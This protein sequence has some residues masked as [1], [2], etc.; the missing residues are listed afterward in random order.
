[1]NI[2]LRPV[3]LVLRAGPHLVLALLLALVVVR[4]LGDPGSG[5]VV[6]LAA[7]IGVVDLVGIVRGDLRLVPARA[8]GTAPDARP[9]GR[10]RSAVAWLAVLVALWIALLTVTPEAVWLA[11][12]LFF[13][14][15]QILPALAGAATLVV[16]VGASVAAYVL[17]TGKLDVGAVLGPV[18]GAAFAAAA[19]HGHAALARESER[20]RL[21]IAELQVAHADLAAASR[22]EGVLAE[23]ERL[24]R[25]IHDTLAQGL[26]SI[27][28]LLR[29][30]ERVLD[31]A[32]TQ[33]ADVDPRAVAELAT[34]ARHVTQARETA[35]ENLVEARRLVRAWT[36][37]ELDAGGLVTALERLAA[38][39]PGDRGRTFVHVSGTA[40]PLGADVDQALLRVA[41]SAVGNA[42]RHADATRIDVTLSFMDDE[43]ALDV[44]DDGRGFDADAVLARGAGADSGFG[45]PGMRARTRALG[46]TL[47]VES[48]VGAGAAISLRVPLGVDRVLDGVGVTEG[49]GPVRPDDSSADVVADVPAPDGGAA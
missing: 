15:L 36:S 12:P 42:V 39:R 34:A 32:A 10:S 29:A 5:T 40:V 11:F 31:S 24:A 30:A 46:G 33:H 3:P 22:N 19:V 13:L 21:L 4:A 25:E 8:V 47:A 7:A 23:R 20:R 2:A 14:V 28:L 16:L 18:L 1:M 49:G 9:V 27:Q 38:P 43:V 6:G 45:L 44:V 37:P 48:S 35:A 41:Q 17:H 26:S